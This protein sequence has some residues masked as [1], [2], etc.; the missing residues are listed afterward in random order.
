[1]NQIL[2]CSKCSK[3]TMKSICECGGDA[4]SAKP[5][6]YTLEDKYAKYRRETKK[7]QR[8]KTGLI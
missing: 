5:P 2:K 3:Y 4:V 8:E 6:K 7:E 1:M